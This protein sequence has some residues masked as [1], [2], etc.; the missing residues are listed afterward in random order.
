MTLILGSE[1]MSEKKAPYITP[2]GEVDLALFIAITDIKQKG[3]G[4]VT[5]KIRDGRITRIIIT[6]ESKLD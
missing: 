5:A 1:A 3:Y 4:E 6:E 2:K